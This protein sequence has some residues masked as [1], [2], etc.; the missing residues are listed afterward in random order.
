MLIQKILFPCPEVC[1]EWE[2]YFRGVSGQR[3]TKEGIQLKKGETLSLE[4]YFNAFSI[5]KWVTYTRIGNLSLELDFCGKIKVRGYHAQGSVYQEPNPEDNM[6]QCYFY[7]KA[8]RDE[9]EIETEAREDGCTVNFPL[10]YKEGI[11]YV[12]LEAEEDTVFYGGGYHSQCREKNDVTLA[13]GICTFKREEFLKKN[14]NLVLSE[15]IHNAD[16]P[17]YNRLEIYISDNGQ[18]VPLDTF[19][20]EKVHLYPNRNVGGAG[21]FTRDMIEALFK[22][23]DSP[24]THMILMDDDIILDC[25]VLE[26]TYAF[27]QLMK[28]EYRNAMLGGELFEL[29]ERYLQFEAGAS[30]RK[31]VIQSYH[32]KWDMRIPDAVSANEIESPLN[33][34]GWW[35]CC[36]PVTFIRKD[37][38][39]IP[40]F[41]HRDDVEYGM[42]NEENG[43]ILLN[44]ICVWHPQGPNKAPVAMNYYDVRNDLIAMCDSP[45]RATK[46]E[47]MNNITRAVLGNILR[48]RYQV[49]ACIFKGLDDFY[50]GPEYLMKLDP[51]E[52]HKN[53]AV[54]NYQAEPLSPDLRPEDIRH[55]LVEDQKGHVFLR[56]ALSCWL[57]PS[58]DE[59]RIS[60]DRDIGCAF[61]AR[62]IYFVDEVHQEGILVEKSYKRAF[63]LFFRY[64]RIMFII[65]TKHEKIMKKWREKKAEYTSLE[66]WEKYLQI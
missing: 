19:P 54:Y 65:F 29:D 18:T 55:E 48:Y 33:F 56:A 8:R 28:E 63:A 15:I 22:R 20:E 12:I 45:T 66:F 60:G 64:L 53:L 57:L 52:N 50:A 35:Y 3:C 40:V 1:D 6:K 11:V 26:R 61:R 25:N 47:I 13:L 37:N 38:L 24:F 5:G 49:I 41:I 9:I 23:K 36:I 42:R 51:V 31:T 34:C 16:S 62:R 7:G 58:R 39:P 32:Q 2:M 59:T 21:G 43:T 14:V 27:L 17:L 30:F 10:Q 44:G 46:G 4:T